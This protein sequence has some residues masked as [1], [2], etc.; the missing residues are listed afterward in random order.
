MEKNEMGLVCSSYGGRER[1]LVEK[2]EEKRPLRRPRRRRG[3]IL[4]WI[5]WKWD[6]G[7]WTGSSWLRIVTGVRH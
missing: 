7:L 3:I 1:V 5:F 4:R 6:V 2:P